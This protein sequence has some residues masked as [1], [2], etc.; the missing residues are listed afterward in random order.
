MATA[1]EIARGI[2]QV[3]ADSY[4]G[5]LDQDGKPLDTGLK[6]G[7]FD[8]KIT[9]RRVNDGFGL[10]LNGNILILNY[11]GEVSVKELH[12]KNFESDTESTL[13]EVL[14]FVKKHYKKVTGNT[15]KC[16]PVGKPNISVQSTSRVHT[17]VEAQMRY[18]I[19]GMDGIATSADAPDGEEL[20]DKSIRDFLGMGKK[21]WGAKKPENVTRKKEQ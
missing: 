9:D 4:D 7:A 14:K 19:Q 12:D 6:R 20:L 3:M 13:A 16:K 18:E 1:E 2:S 17:W 11:E 10:S 8:T 15:L 21:D 5:A